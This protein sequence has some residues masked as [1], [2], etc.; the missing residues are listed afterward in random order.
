MG[1][2]F[3]LGVGGGG[4]WAEL[5][6]CPYPPKVQ[7]PPCR[8]SEQSFQ[9]AARVLLYAPSH[10]QDSTDHSLCYISHEALAGMRNSS[11]GCRIRR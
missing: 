1:Y 4:G 9:L 7:A 8:V 11:V 5:F 10:R 3:Q 2:S 6:L